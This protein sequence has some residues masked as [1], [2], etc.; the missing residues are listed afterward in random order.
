[1][2]GFTVYSPPSV[3][4]QEIIVP[5]GINIPAQPFAVCLVGTGSR[6]KRVT[7]EAVVRGIVKSETLTVAGSS[8]HTTTLANRSNRK[9]DNLTVYRTLNSIRTEI[10]DAYITHNPARVLGTVT[11]TADLSA[12]NAI[13]LEM[14][15]IAAVTIIF[16]DAATAT[17]ISGRQITVS[18]ALGGVAG[19]ASTMAEIALAINQGLA[20]ATSLGYGSAY[21]GVATT[22]AGALLI[23]SPAI[24]SSG[25]GLSNSDVRVFAPFSNSALTTIF[26]APAVDNSNRDA[27][28]TIRI[29]D[30]VWNASATWSA[31]YVKFTDDTDPLAQ[32]SNIQSLVA[33]GSNPGSVNFQSA[34]DYQ[35]T[36]NEV[37]W[38]PDTAAVLTGIAGAAAGNT[39]DI[40]PGDQLWLRI[41]GKID[42]VSGTVTAI[43]DL[44]DAALNTPVVLGYNDPTNADL[45]TAAENVVN[46][47]ALAARAWGPRYAAIATAPTVDGTPRVRITSPTE[48]TAS[49]IEVLAATSNS[50]HLTIFG[51]E[52]TGSTT[53][54]GTGMRPTLGSTY[55]VSYEFTRPTTEYNV[56]YRH[57]SVDT[58]LAQVGQPSPSV[59]LYNPLAIATQ[60]AF[61]NGVE[62]IYTIQVNDSTTEGSPTRAQVQSALNG[63]KTIKGATEVVVVDEPGTRLDVTTDEIAHLEDECAPTAKHR[64]RIHCGMVNNSVIGDRDTVNS[65]VG[66]ATRTLVVAPTSPGRGRM[67][68]LA[69]PQPAGVTKTLA[70]EDGVSARI[71]LNGTYLAV[72]FAASRTALAG[73]AETMT[74]KTIRGFNTDDITAAW[75]PAETNT[76]ASQGVLVVTFDAGRFIILDA[77]TTEAGNG[78]LDAFKVDSTSYQKD[79]VVDKVETAI[80][81]NI[82]SI[83]PF[84]LTSFLLDLKLVAQGVIATEIS[85]GTIGPYRDDSGAIRSIDLRTDIRA[86]QDVSSQT[87]Y[88]LN[89]WFNLRYPALRVFAS[90]SVDRSFFAALL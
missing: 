67:F 89:Y 23:T 63:A 35:L 42:A 10:L 27:V 87:N 59:A 84:D 34:R 8:P 81:T 41:D 31:D 50:A 72:A 79:I 47:N 43:M 33:V 6:N 90:Y 52:F 45:A 71:A 17:A 83:V 11:A 38:T 46:I 49:S 66:R 55:F 25:N 65:L 77:I 37:D 18:S 26:G 57:F 76:M 51:A 16:V 48:G 70:F 62:F 24:D 61:E 75:S 56:P 85:N 53:K 36:S 5:S 86:V 88:N 21:A 14:D 58:A 73:P 20:A 44:N 30:A 80:D 29:G 7:N 12:N 74:R 28:T 19:A 82:I 9:L 78:N 3:V 68:L 69:P 13:A 2:A 54:L 40:N 39:F 1:M 32:T 22:S 15:G 4:S 60:I 64:R